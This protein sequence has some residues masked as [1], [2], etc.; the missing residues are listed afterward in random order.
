MNTNNILSGCSENINI[1][2]HLLN[3]SA[4]L[5]Q[6]SATKIHCA[7]ISLWT[8]D[9]NDLQP[10]PSQSP[11]RNDNEMTTEGILARMIYIG[12]L[13]D[14]M[15]YYVYEEDDSQPGPG[16][17]EMVSKSH[18]YI[19][20]SPDDEW[21]ILQEYYVQV[22]HNYR[23]NPDRLIEDYHR[24]FPNRKVRC[25]SAYRHD[26][27]ANRHSHKQHQRLGGPCEK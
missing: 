18:Q 8:D 22:L 24:L 7:I 1:D 13:V 15:H 6:P 3:Y 26:K 12:A 19:S 10:Q 23:I 21:S 5:K 14:A 17:T 16:Y 11:S 25:L 9:I 4:R 2:H 27:R 20:I